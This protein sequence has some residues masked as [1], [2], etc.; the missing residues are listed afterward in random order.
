MA[1]VVVTHVVGGPGRPASQASV[2]QVWETDDVRPVEGPFPCE[3][4]VDSLALFPDGRRLV[5]GHGDGTARIWDGRSDSH[6]G[7]LL[8]A[9]EGLWDPFS[10]KH[11][12]GRTL[13][14]RGHVHALSVSPDGRRILSGGRN[15][16]PGSGM[17]RMAG[18]SASRSGIGPRSRPSASAATAVAPSPR[19]GMARSGPGM[20]T[21]G[22]RPVRP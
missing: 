4:Q 13:H 18:R 22:F 9:Q 15:G 2:V 3:A 19:A 11:G 17:P 21:R 7:P 5:V 16:M 6:R 1:T 20:P 14:P 12:D 10:R 8:P